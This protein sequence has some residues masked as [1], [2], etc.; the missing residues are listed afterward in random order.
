MRHLCIADIADPGAAIRVAGFWKLGRHGVDCLTNEG[1]MMPCSAPTRW[2]I[3]ITCSR[4]VCAQ[5]E[6]SDRNFICLRHRADPAS[7]GD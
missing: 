5:P 1:D 7:T 3:L 2:S 4:P 6:L